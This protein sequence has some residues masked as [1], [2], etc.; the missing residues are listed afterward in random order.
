[1]LIFLDFEGAVLF[2]QLYADIYIH[3]YIVFFVFIV[4]YIPVAELAYTFY[5]FTLAVNKRQY[6][7]IIFFTNSIVICTEGRGSVY[8]TGTI[9]SSYEITYQYPERIAAASLSFVS[10]K[11]QEL[12]ITATFYF[13]SFKFKCN[14]PI[15]HSSF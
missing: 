12:L 7:D 9:F 13:F 2:F 1:M 4:L 5:K 3:V 10:F 11:R 14:L 6:A 15:S 8:D